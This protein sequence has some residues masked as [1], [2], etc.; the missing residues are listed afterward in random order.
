MKLKLSILAIILLITSQNYLAQKK[1]AGQSGMTYLAI[2]LGA[3]ESA[4]GNASVASVNGTQGLFYN[5]AVLTNIEGF[6]FSMNHVSWIADTRLYAFGAAYD[7]QDYGALGIDLVYMDYGQII[8]TKRV[9]KSIDDR[10]FIITGDLSISDY[11]VGLAY[12]YPV[13]DV[14]SFGVKYK[15]IHENLGNAEIAVKEIDRENGIY[16]YET[17]EWQINHWGFDFG[18][19]YKVGFKDLTIG[20]AFQNFSTDM[21]YW[22]EVFQLPLVLRMGLAM[23]LMKLFENGHSDFQINTAMDVL[24]P[25]DYTERVHLGTEIVYKEIFALRSGYKFNYDV[26]DFSFGIGV[27]FDLQGYKGSF[28]YSY[29]HAQF[30][31]S[32]N[33]FSINFNF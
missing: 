18:G 2:S 31:E 15:F 10:G 13:N 1:K 6:G 30:F 33:R 19:Y 25:I 5:P 9:D 20:V 7:F 12:A 14:F 24:H 26:E 22:T 27:K 4:M 17:R 29:T 23:D 8:G 21:K 11:A 32:I 16:E 3:R 28:D